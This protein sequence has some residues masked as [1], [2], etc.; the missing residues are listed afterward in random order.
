MTK[1][2][3]VWKAS[4]DEVVAAV[5]RSF[6]LVQVLIE[7]GAGVGGS[8]SSSLR[9]RCRTE[10]IDFSKFYSKGKIPAEE[11][12]V[13]DSH[14]A[15]GVVRKR[16]LK[17]K[18]IPYTC[19]LCEVGPEW[20]GRPLS[21]VLDHINGIHNDHRLENLRFLCPNCNAQTPTYGGKNTALAGTSHTS[22][23]ACGVK[24]RKKNISGMCGVCW[25]KSSKAKAQREKRRKVKNRPSK[26]ELQVLIVEN[27]WT[28]IGRMYGVIANTV[29]K[30]AKAYGLPT[31][32]KKKPVRLKACS[33]CGGACAPR[34]ASGICRSCRTPS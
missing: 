18:Q 5:E 22:C 33:V 31:I 11:L 19:A 32:R 1:R 7:L 20:K 30:W 15:R 3:R 6:S 27:T 29:R 16:L 26:E 24:I 28:G 13:Q 17:E 4:R 23:G 10:N 14:T 21:L 8:S 34:C 25:N 2:S 12:F 9:K